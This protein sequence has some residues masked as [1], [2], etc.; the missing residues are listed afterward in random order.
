MA[1]PLRLLILEDRP[2]DAELMGHALHQA[3]FAPIWDRVETEADYLA[4]LP[5]SPDV[6]LAD[7][8][9]PQFDALR[10]LHLLQERGRDIPFIVVTR[11]VSEEAAVACMKQGAADYLLKDRLTRLGPA[12]QRVLLEKH[13]RDEKRRDA[14]ALRES[15]ARYRT[16]VEASVQGICIDQEG[17]VQFA[18][19]AMARMFGY[20]GP[21][22][23]IGQEFQGMVAPS[24]RA[25]LEE[26]Q[27]AH[28]QGAPAPSRCEYQGLCKDG[29]LIWLECLVA[30][31]ISP[32]PNGCAP[33][34]A[35]TCGSAS[36][37]GRSP[38]GGGCSSGAASPSSRSRS[39]R[40][41]RSR[42]PCWSAARAAGR[43]RDR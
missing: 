18:N 3:G 43:L 12:V 30:P 35:A 6:I 42:T 14:A 22:A 2:A 1:T 34:P 8:T 24:E 9:L 40:A 5:E 4:R 39:P 26:Y 38:T 27:Q 28:L 33:W 19:P 16:L 36:A 23:L 25:R 7:Y 13:L 10:A 37:T 17:T 20:D 11:T 15:E 31:V 32:A 41:R 21:D 29:R